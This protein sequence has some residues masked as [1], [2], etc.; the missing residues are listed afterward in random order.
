MDEARENQEVAGLQQ[1]KQ[2]ADSGNPEALGQ[3][4][5]IVDQLLQAQQAEMQGGQEEQGG[6]SFE[7]KLMA[8]HK[9]KEA[10]AQNG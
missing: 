7:E 2:L 6:G 9:A 4:S 8:A 10:G 5:Q 3:I 1:I